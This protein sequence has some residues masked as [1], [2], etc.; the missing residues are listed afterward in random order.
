MSKSEVTLSG[1]E[2]RLEELGQQH[3][4]K[5]EG[6]FQCNICGWIMKYKQNAKLHVESKHFPTMNGYYCDLCSKHFNTYKA[7]KRH[8][9]CYHRHEV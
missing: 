4:V 9:D 2:A 3:L 7:L 5:Q 8:N 1:C 6:G